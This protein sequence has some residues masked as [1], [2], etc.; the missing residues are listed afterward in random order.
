MENFNK[1]F[2]GGYRRIVGLCT[3][4]LLNPYAYKLSNIIKNYPI[5]KEIKLYLN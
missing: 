1:N 5:I 3:R 4:H 2:L